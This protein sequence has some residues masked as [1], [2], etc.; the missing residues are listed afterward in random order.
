MVAPDDIGL[1][2]QDGNNVPGFPLLG[3]ATDGVWQRQ[4]IPNGLGSINVA[5]TPSEGP[6]IGSIYQANLRFTEHRIVTQQQTFRRRRNGSLRLIS[7]GDIIV[8]GPIFSLRVLRRKLQD[9]DPNNDPVPSMTLYNR[10][11]MG[12]GRPA[13]PNGLPAARPGVAAARI[14]V[15]A[16][17]VPGGGAVP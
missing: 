6:R 12:G 1:T 17:F 13:V 8:S 16:G 10:Y 14:N 7:S 15:V 4:P 3:M 2:D 9:A 5:I 11:L